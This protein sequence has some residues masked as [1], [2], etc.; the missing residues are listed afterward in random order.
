MV[1]VG[2]RESS[3]AVLPQAA[4]MSAATDAFIFRTP[5]IFILAA[6]TSS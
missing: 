2:S 5:L 4:Q 3:F 6:W 1:C